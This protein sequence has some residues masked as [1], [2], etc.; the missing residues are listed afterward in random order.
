MRVRI[1][2]PLFPTRFLRDSIIVIRPFS[3]Y[4][5]SKHR[6]TFT[7]TTKG[8]I[9]CTRASITIDHQRPSVS[10]TKILF[11]DVGCASNV[12]GWS[13]LKS[14]ILRRFGPIAPFPF[15]LRFFFPAMSW[16]RDN[17]PACS[18]G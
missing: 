18:D 6:K 15:F 17:P 13:P 12:L 4:A 1:E 3:L 10:F 2:R 16:T 14:N 7:S 5:Y 8:A 11:L 9:I